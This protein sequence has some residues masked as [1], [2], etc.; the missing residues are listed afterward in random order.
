MRR[1]TTHLHAQA[2]RSGVVAALLQGRVS[3]PRYAL[4]LR[5]L[6]PAYQAME[7]AL[8]QNCD[9]PGYQELAQPALRRSASIVSDLG[10]LAG[11]DWA[12]ALPLLS[13]GE[14]YA[15]RVEFAAN[16]GLLIAHCYT[17]SLGD[18]NGGQI[19]RRRLTQTFGP[20]F[21]AH[22]F[23]TFP[24]IP[25]PRGFSQAYRVSLDRAGA[26]LPDWEPIIDEAAIAFTMNIHL[27]VEVEAF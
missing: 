25:D 21:Q 7:Q 24:G 5:N 17:R 12:T 13:S 15:A 11:P 22:A 6:L 18:L 9:R 23:T 14:E 4:Y 16:D 20:T 8:Q 10:A 2:E 27:S 1:R 19:L 3:Q 26:D